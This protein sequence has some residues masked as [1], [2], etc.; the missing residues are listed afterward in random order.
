MSE[1]LAKVGR[2]RQAEKEG[3][4]WIE[5]P[6]MRKDIPISVGKL[7]NKGGDCHMLAI[8]DLTAIFFWFYRE[9]VSDKKA[10]VAEAVSNMIEN[11][12]EVI[13]LGEEATVMAYGT[14]AE[15]DNAEEN[16][17][18]GGEEAAHSIGVVL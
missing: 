16:M 13:A 11:K 7:K 3:K 6:K 2:I 8:A 18:I 1:A 15:A 14:K 9:E 10:V 4:K 12:P 5:I 17:E